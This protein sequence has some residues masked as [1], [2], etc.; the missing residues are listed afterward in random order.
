M[1]RLTKKQLNEQ[2]LITCYGQKEK[3]RREDAIDFYLEGI[4]CSD[5]SERERY[6]AIYTQLMQGCK[7]ATDEYC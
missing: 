4:G 2:V 1:K 6:Y 7:T 5:G 3:M